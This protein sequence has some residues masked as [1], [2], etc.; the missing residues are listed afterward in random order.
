MLLFPFAFA[1]AAGQPVLALRQHA[2]ASDTQGPHLQP[3]QSGN[4]II[5]I[6]TAMVCVYLNAQF[7]PTPRNHDKQ[8]IVYCERNTASKCAMHQS[9]TN[10]MRG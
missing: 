10:T 5:W 9:R 3:Q 1:A 7:A 8:K 4:R 2:G 6:E